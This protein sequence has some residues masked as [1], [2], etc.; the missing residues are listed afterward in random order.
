LDNWF[1]KVKQHW[2]PQTRF[3]LLSMVARHL[4]LKE[5]MDRMGLSIPTS[6]FSS[7][8]VLSELVLFV[9]SRV[10]YSNF[11]TTTATS[12]FLLRECTTSYYVVALLVSLSLGYRSTRV[13]P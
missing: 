13:H 5:L 9:V 12:F 8:L 2:P 3:M 4:S 7:P 6:E 1:G 10:Q 11:G